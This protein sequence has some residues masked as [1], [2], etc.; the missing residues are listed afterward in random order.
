MK[1][2]ADQEVTVSKCSTL[3]PPT[4]RSE[5]K[6]ALKDM[7]NGKSADVDDIPAELWKASG[8]SGIDP[9][10]NL[11]KRILTDQEWP[12]DRCRIVYVTIHK[13]GSKIECSNYRTI[14]LIVHA[15]KILLKI[16]IYRIKRKYSGEIS[17]E[18]VGFVPERGKREHI[19]NTR[20][21]IENCTGHNIPYYM[22]FIDY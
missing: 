18:H 22:C 20:L 11:C 21:V 17:D 10:W 16:I 1:D 6:S 7:A 8:E 2:P 12:K 14:S 5:V 13:K 3:D 4:M 19:I 9:L 15:S